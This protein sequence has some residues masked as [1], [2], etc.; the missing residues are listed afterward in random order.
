MQSAERKGVAG[1][2]LPAITYAD[3]VA[4]KTLVRMWK[5]IRNR[6]KAKKVT[7]WV[8]NRIEEI[9]DELNEACANFDLPHMVYFS[10]FILEDLQRRTRKGFR[11]KSL[12]ELK[13]A[14]DGLSNLIDPKGDLYPIYDDSKRMAEIVY[15]GIGFVV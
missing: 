9:Q 4:T 8:I 10:S 5:G 14:V 1:E 12:D 13:E 7:S 15:R 3:E 11:G 2:Y 6:N